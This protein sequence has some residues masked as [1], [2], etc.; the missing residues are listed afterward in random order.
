MATKKNCHHQKEI[1]KQEKKD[2]R[3]F[4]LGEGQIV[5]ETVHT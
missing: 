5:L 3:A 4:D 1:E 2:M